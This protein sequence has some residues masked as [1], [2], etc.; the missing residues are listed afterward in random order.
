MTRLI[1]AASLIAAI[2]SALDGRY[3]RAGALTLVAAGSAA[4]GR[5]QRREAP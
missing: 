4:A 2:S 3:A 5:R 1:A